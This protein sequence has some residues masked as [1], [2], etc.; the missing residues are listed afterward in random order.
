MFFP[1]CTQ[2]LE[3]PFFEKKFTS[4]CI[5]HN[6]WKLFCHGTGDNNPRVR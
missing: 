2:W 1:A 6:S 5:H 3:L 4:P